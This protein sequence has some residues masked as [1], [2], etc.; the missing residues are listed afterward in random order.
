MRKIKTSNK[1]IIIALVVTLVSLVAYDFLLKA[2]YRSGNYKIP[3]KNY[4]TLNW[5][6]F[7]IVDINASTA[8]NVKLV[9]GPFS[10]RVEQYAAEYVQVKQKGNRLEIDA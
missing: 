10:V 9:Q 7:D 4:V 2:E 1:L 5:K 6:D 3:F 8:A